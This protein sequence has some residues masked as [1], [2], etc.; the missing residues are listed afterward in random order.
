[1]RIVDGRDDLPPVPDNPRIAKQARDIGLAKGRATAKSKRAN[2]ARK[3]S[4]FLRM[5]SQD[6]PD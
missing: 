3:F 4:R 2:A 5:V 1:L 6:R